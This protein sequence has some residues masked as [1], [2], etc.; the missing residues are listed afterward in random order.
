MDRESV[1]RE[2]KRTGHYLDTDP[3]EGRPATM[4]GGSVGG[5]ALFSRRV[6]F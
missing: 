2:A 5:E 3:V 6:H 4:G 1:A